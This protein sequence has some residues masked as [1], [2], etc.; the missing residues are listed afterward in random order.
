MSKRRRKK[1]DRRPNLPPNT[2]RAA[3]S[4]RVKEPLSSF[5]ARYDFNPDYSYVVKDLKRIG[6]LAGSFIFL[7][8]VLSFFLR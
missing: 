6:A 3:A 1:R 2:L 4:T 8:I 7:L 5:Q